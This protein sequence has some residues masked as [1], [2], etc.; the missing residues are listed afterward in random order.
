MSRRHKED[1]LPAYK[2]FRNCKTDTQS[3]LRFVVN[4]QKSLSGNAKS[5]YYY[6]LLMLLFLF[7]W[8]ILVKEQKKKKF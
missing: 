6:K 5:V 7:L 4:K 3:Y 1:Y 2:K 8:T